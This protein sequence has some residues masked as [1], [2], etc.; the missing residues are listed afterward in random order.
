MPEIIAQEE[1]RL[2]FTSGAKY[3]DGKLPMDLLPPEALRQVAA[4]LAYGAT[5]YETWN[6]RKGMKW[7]RLIA[8]TF[9]HLVTFMDGED[10]DPESGLPHLAHAC[11]NLCF[12][13]QYVKEHPEFDDRYVRPASGSSASDAV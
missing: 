8:A 2:G 1:S 7:S 3:D 11:C 6:W 10:A 13:L 5:K 4:I 9:R 12:L